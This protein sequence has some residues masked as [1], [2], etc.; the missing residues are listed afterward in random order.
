MK[1][2][3]TRLRLQHQ[4]TWAQRTLCLQNQRHTPLLLFYSL[5]PTVVFSTMDSDLPALLSC[6]GDWLSV[7]QSMRCAFEHL[8]NIQTRPSWQCCLCSLQPLDNRCK[9]SSRQQ[10]V[11]KKKLKNKNMKAAQPRFDGALCV[12]DAGG[13]CMERHIAGGAVNAAL[14]VNAHVCFW[15]SSRTA[16]QRVGG[17]GIMED[18]KCRSL[19]FLKVFVR[20][21]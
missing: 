17:V 9:T 7:R 19:D 1:K 3:K 20:T 4:A 2:I 15:P 18:L 11:G 5:H 10:A 6:H 12:K 8:F 13:S 16:T 14:L 21:P